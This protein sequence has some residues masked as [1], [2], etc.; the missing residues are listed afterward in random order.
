MQFLRLK[1][2][3][4]SR[5]PQAIGRCNSDQAELIEVVNEAQERLIFAG[6]EV[7]WWG[8]WARMVFNVDSVANPYVTLPRNVARLI[9]LDV[10]RFPVRIQNEFYEFLEAGIGLQPQ[11]NCSGAI[12]NNC[13]ALET[14]DRGTFPTMVDLVAGNKRL[15]AY[16][17]DAGDYTKRVLFQGSDA[18]GSTIYSL[19]GFDQVLGIYVSLTTP[20]VDTPLDFSL[21]TGIQKDVTIGPV[22]IYEVDTVTGTQRLLVT[23]QPSEEVAAY[24]RYFLNGLPMNCCTPPLA[25]ATTSQVQVTA[26]AKL[27]FI[28]VLADTD[29]LMI[30]S[31]AA[32]KEECQ[33]VRFSEMDDSTSLGQADERH[34]KAIRLL[35]GQ[36]RHKLG[37]EHP[38][39]NFAPFGTAKLNYQRIGSLT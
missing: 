21:I 2:V 28:P 25:P 38:A 15:R 7:G 22:Q 14:Y 11:I 10:C 37:K 24:R 16:A 31:L 13:N 32:L 4:T 26:M 23:M 19:D 27:E 35:N 29:Y 18:N 34:K 5:I 30:Q 20:F 33:A 6:G 9:N 8:S 3:R 17:T 1:D 12:I 39:I 36:L